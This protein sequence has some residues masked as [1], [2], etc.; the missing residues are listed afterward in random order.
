MKRIDLPLI[1]DVAFYGT[2]AWFLSLGIL[3]YF[4]LPLALALLC[5]TLIA[6]SAGGAIFL[7][8]YF[9]HKKA[10]LNAAEKER[11][12]KLLLHLALETDERVRLSLMNA[13]RADGK[14][15]HCE[16]DALRS[17][18]ELLV[19]RFTMQPLSAD[20]VALLVK[21]YRAPF[22]LVC[23]DTTP[24]ADRLLRSFG[25]ACIRGDEVYALFAR[26]QFPDPLI[27]G[28]IP[29]RKLRARLKEA[30]SKRNAR[31]FFV[32]GILLLFMSLF[33][34]FPL[35]YLLT[36]SALLIVSVFVRAVGYA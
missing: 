25:I 36:G 11:R 29:R 33:T 18:G 9:G 19:P 1:L 12:D 2:A 16:G 7:A 20:A 10:R 35:Y 34:L 24:E 21:Q 27:C 30:F 17:D 5:A 22:T 3:R 6:L 14:D 31:P 26:T 15:V 13:Y 28:E 23:N 8:L 4:R 32:S